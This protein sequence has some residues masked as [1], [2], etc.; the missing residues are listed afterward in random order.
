M[1]RPN[2]KFPIGR[3]F[4]SK[5]RRTKSCSVGLYQIDGPID[6]K[7]AIDWI[8]TIK[9]LPNDYPD[10]KVLMLVISSS[11]GSLGAAQTIVE[12]IDVLRTEIDVETV[13]VI[14]SIATSS[15]Y[16]VACSAS[17]I[18]ATPS[19]LVGNVGSVAPKIDWQQAGRRFGLEYRSTASGIYKEMLNPLFSNT[20]DH[21][22][23]IGLMVKAQCD[24]F[25]K[26]VLSKRNIRKDQLENLK[27]GLIFTAEAGVKYG[28]IDEIGGLLP[29]LSY[30]GE[31]IGAYSVE[32]V[33]L[34]N[35]HQN[36][37]L[38]DKALG[39]IS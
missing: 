17:R 16:Y 22:E 35:A 29:C 5:I 27:E 2:K 9:A 25:Y 19:A 11:G 39:F 33:S 12:G 15:A 28:I 21:D 23:A 8:F 7:T 3:S 10:I 4:L 26:Y 36:N 34:N 31:L 32:T 18:Y 13:A 6:D 1:S 24:Q 37:S 20:A 14:P 30:C 38:L